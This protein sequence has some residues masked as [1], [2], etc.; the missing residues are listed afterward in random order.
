MTAA[1]E[2][3]KQILMTRPDLLHPIDQKMLELSIDRGQVRSPHRS[4]QTRHMVMRDSDICRQC[5]HH[6]SEV[7]TNTGALAGSDRHSDDSVWWIKQQQQQ[8]QQQQEEDCCECGGV[9][10]GGMRD[11]MSLP[12][13]AS[14]QVFR[15]IAPQYYSQVSG[16]RAVASG[17]IT[18]TGMQSC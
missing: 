18:H 3:E 16:S 8:Q 12:H 5:S 7:Y 17:V 1:M 9:G 10:G 14:P 15:H 4:V 6:D 2:R 11:A 13:L